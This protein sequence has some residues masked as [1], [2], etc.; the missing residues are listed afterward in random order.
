MQR[1]TV[2]VGVL[3]FV[4][5]VCAQAAE[6]LPYVPKGVKVLR[7]LA[8][9]ENGHE[10]QKLNLFLPEKKSDKPLPLVIVVHGGAWQSGARGG[11]AFGNDLLARGEAAVAS[12]GYR[13]SDDAPFPAQIQD[14]KAAV[15][16]LRAHAKEYNLDPERFAASGHSAGGHLVALLGTSGGVKAFD[17]GAHLDQS[18]RLQAVVD[19]CGPVDLML[20][21]KHPAVIKLLGGP[22]QEKASLA[23]LANPITHLSKEAPPF[24]IQQGDTDT[25]VPLKHSQ[26]LFEALKTAGVSVHLHTIHGAGHGDFWEPAMVAMRDEF[27]ERMLLGKP[28]AKAKPEATSS[29]SKFERSPTPENKKNKPPV[30]AIEPIPSALPSVQVFVPGFAVRELPVKLTNLVNIEYA[31]DGRLFAAGYDGRIHM[32]TDTDDDGL[33]VKVTTIWDKTSADYPLG[34]VVHDQGVYVLLKDELVRF[35]DTHG[36]GVP[37][38]REVVLENWDDPKT[39]QHPL[40]LKRR[41]DYGMGLAIGPDGSIYIGMGNGAYSNAYML[42]EKGELGAKGKSHYEPKNGRGCV[43]KFSPD[44]NKKELLLTGV[45]YL[46]SMQF[47]SHGDLFATDQEGATWLPNGNPFDELLHLQPGRHYG[48]PPEA[49]EVSARSDRRAERLRLRA[50]ASKCVRISVQRRERIRSVLVEG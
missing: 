36:D 46:M 23:A 13:L 3:V 35:V 30:P 47:N 9:V 27:L 31:P 42:D 20:Y 39:A 7:D 50:A 25:T 44:G 22:P 32:L 26:L 4:S 40:I 19:M 2:G 24:L 37:D 29:E 15:R 45:R 1:A 49:S 8:Y 11:P 12:L 48:F 41:V 10:R 14:C 43:L 16:W 38:K 17:V 34:M 21:P 33:E 5:L 6:P 18:S 28:D